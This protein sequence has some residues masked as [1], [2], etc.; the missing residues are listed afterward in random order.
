MSERDQQLQQLIAAVCQATPQSW[1]WQQ[2]MTLLLTQV[3]ALP[4]L[5]RS[6]HPNYPD[7]LNETLAELGDRLCREFQ[8]QP[9]LSLETSLVAWINKKLRLKYRVQ[10]L[11]EPT[12]QPPLPLEID[13]PAPGPC[14][15]WELEAEIEQQQQ[16]QQAMTVGRQLQQYVEQDPQGRLRQCHPGAYPAANAQVLSQRLLIKSPPDKLAELARELE[17]PYQ[18]LYWHWK[19]K[20]LPLLQE[21]AQNFGYRP[22]RKI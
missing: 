19:N 5:A 22:D 7:V 4:G 17:V 11:Y 20:V 12:R 1:Q 9:G 15:L 18:A 21:I 6:S 2:A 13:L 3:L 10:D 8:P 16:Q 14:T